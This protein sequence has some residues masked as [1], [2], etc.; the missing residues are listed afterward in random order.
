MILLLSSFKF[1]RGMQC[2]GT[3]V[4]SAM[5]QSLQ[6]AEVVTSIKSNDSRILEFHLA[7][8]AQLALNCAVQFV[9]KQYYYKLNF[10]HSVMCDSLQPCGLQ[11]DRLFYPWNSPGK[12]IGVDSHF[13]LQRISLTQGLNLGL[14]HCR[15]M[16]YCLS[17]QIT[18]QS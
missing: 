6:V 16:L 1:Y 2:Q 5:S 17:H 8:S 18:A 3:S 11:S 12:N 10:S 14:L 13:L 9:I 4:T 7:H 15:Q